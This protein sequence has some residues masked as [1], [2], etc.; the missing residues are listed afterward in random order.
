MFGNVN[1][2]TAYN[3]IAQGMAFFPMDNASVQLVLITFV[4]IIALYGLIKLIGH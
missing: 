4:L 2:N 1:T 3:Q